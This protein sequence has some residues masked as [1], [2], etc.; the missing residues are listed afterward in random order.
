MAGQLDSSAGRDCGHDVD[1]WTAAV[2]V[3]IV[4]LM[5]GIQITLKIA[6]VIGLFQV[7]ALIPGTPRGSGITIN[8]A[9]LWG[10]LGLRR[11]VFHSC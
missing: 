9:L 3:R 2:G 7:L 4:N 10:C 8:A 11:L 6:L 1:L 5:L